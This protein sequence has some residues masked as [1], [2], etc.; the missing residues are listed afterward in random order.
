[1]AI[2]L[3]RHGKYEN[4]EK[5]TPFRLPG[6]PLSQ[7]GI[8]QAK[9]LA[10]YFADKN[11][12]AIFTSPITR[13]KQ[14]AEIIGSKLGLIPKISDLLIETNS[15]YA[16]NK[17]EYLHK[18]IKNIFMS[19]FHIGH[20][21]DLIDQIFARMKRMIDSILINFQNKSAICVSHGDP[22]MIYVSRIIGQPFSGSGDEKYSKMS[23]IQMGG[24]IKIVGDDE[25]NLKIEQVSIT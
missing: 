20:N 24:V 7:E 12:T 17:T 18:E 1:M 25:N 19:Q 21:G 4:P 11:I 3:V 15:A 8:L 9:N 16:G 13:A 2:Y 10:D 23:Y 14:T 6:Y 5:I 22:I